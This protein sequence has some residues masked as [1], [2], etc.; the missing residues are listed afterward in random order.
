MSFLAP[1][2]LLGA[3]AIVGPI[4]FHLIRRTTREVTPFSTLMFLKPTPPRV[5]RR[6]RLE[7]LWLLL[8]RCLVIA[9]LA[10][11]FGRPFLQREEASSGPAPGSGRRLVV[12]VDRSA[13]MRREGLWEQAQEKAKSIL[14]TTT[15]EDEAAVFA[16][17]RGLTEVLPFADWKAA[18][19]TQRAGLAEERL[20]AIQP[21]WGATHLDSALLEASQRMEQPDGSRPLREEIVVVSDMQEGAQLNALQGYEWPK[22]L[23]I[24]L[25]TVSAK[26]TGNAGLHWLPEAE[27]GAQ[28]GEDTQL[29]FRVGNAADATTDQYQLQWIGATSTAPIKAYA[30]AGQSRV[31]RVSAPGSSSAALLLTGDADDFDNAAYVLPPKPAQTPVLFVGQDA[32]DDTRGLLYYM[33]RAFPPT[34]RLAVEIIPHREPTSV[35]AFQLES[36]QLLI[37]GENA[38]DAAIASARQFAIDGKMVLA[39][40]TSP[41]SSIAVAKL[42]EIP[43]LPATE[44]GAK[45]YGLL[46]EIDFRHAFFSVFADPRFSDFSKI[47][48]WK[49]RQIDAAALPDARIVA[50]FDRGDPAIVQ[51][52]L[53]KG[54]VVIFTSTWRPQDSQLALS[55][56]FVPLMHALL[57]ESSRA[58]AQRAQY[59]VGDEVELPKAAA[60]KSLRR[61]DGSE[62]SLTEIYRGTDEPGLYETADRSVRFVVNLAPEESRTMPLLAARLSSLGVPLARDAASPSA[63]EKKRADHLQATELESRQ[64]LWRWLLVA[65]VSI[66]LLETL[67]AGKLSH[68]PREAVA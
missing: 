42:L 27:T 23:T 65:V 3:A 55:S 12:L 40:L 13:S 26:T 25:E 14:E 58:P 7:N 33:R 35:P 34:Q 46:G 38:P 52:P 28:A 60:G 10:L 37:L 53:G 30:P 54:S 57:E 21:G 51:V 18:D 47:H 20:T 56:K 50:K 43:Q 24:A 36:A 68:S 39:P 66:L 6:S 22:L 29:R 48:F 31:V 59:F 67:I 9:L 2:F 64:K 11:S 19:P 63:E 49:H 17:D 45:D 62:T 15:P 32:P 16:F 61:P 44:A 5:T 1:L 41:E 8:L 4:I